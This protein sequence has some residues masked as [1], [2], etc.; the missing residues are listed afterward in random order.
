MNDKEF[1]EEIMGGTPSQIP[2]AYELASPRWYVK[3]GVPS[4]L[5]MTDVLDHGS[6]AEMWKDVRA[7][8]SDAKLLKIAGGLHILQQHADP[9]V[10]E[11]GMSTETPEAWI[12]ID[13][14]LAKTVGRP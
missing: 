11:A 3:P 7:A 14:F 2:H 4:F 5:L 8:G 12:A 10:Y 6:A 9:G 1:V 13:D